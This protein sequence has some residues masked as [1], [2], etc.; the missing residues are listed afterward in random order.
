MIA[1]NFSAFQTTLLLFFPVCFSTFRSLSRI[2][3]LSVFLCSS[4]HVWV[5]CISVFNAT[6]FSLGFVQGLGLVVS[7][8]KMSKRCPLLSCHLAGPGGEAV[9]SCCSVWCSSHPWACNCTQPLLHTTG[10][11]YF[12]PVASGFLSWHAWNFFYSRLS[13]S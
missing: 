6:L 4:C 12:G 3:A 7:G 8:T 5:L 9:W 10:S 2:V 13:V 11:S 1:V